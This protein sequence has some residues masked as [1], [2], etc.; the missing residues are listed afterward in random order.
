M[1]A[2]LVLQERGS[3][4]QLT[5]ITYA[6]LSALAV[7]IPVPFLDD[8]VS[9]YFARQMVAALARIYRL[10]LSPQELSLL[11]TGRGRG[12]MALLLD[13][14]IL[15]S[16]QLLMRRLLQDLFFLLDLSAAGQQF[17]MCYYQGYLLD[18]LFAEGAYR[19]GSLDN[20][21]RVNAA[22]GAVS[23]QAN[24]QALAKVFT[25]MVK[26]SRA[27]VRHVV[28]L[29]TFASKK[30]YRQLARIRLGRRAAPPAEIP[31]VD[32]LE[33]LPE[34]RQLAEEMYRNIA[35]M[36]SDHLTELKARLKARLENTDPAP[37][38]G[39]E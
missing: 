26:N 33:K 14:G 25:V 4:S 39:G 34:V 27:V 10:E 28:S 1:D 30:A 18:S 38:R 24:F 2:L 3:R 23:G 17:A 32:E 37:S 5:I 9:A 12:C 19:P 29:A 31:L 7:L 35:L 36:P 6:L 11:A 21:R 20:A 22:L 13:R 15:F 16:V 8:S